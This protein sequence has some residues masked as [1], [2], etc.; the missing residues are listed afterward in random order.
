M[1]IYKKV[2]LDDHLVKV[3]SGKKRP[4]PTQENLNE[5]FNSM[6]GTQGAG[7]DLDLAS[8]EEKLREELTQPYIFRD[9][10]LNTAENI[11]IFG[12]FYHRIWQQLSLISLSV[13]I[14]H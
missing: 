11:L 8:P 4:A 14:Q 3:V 12:D 9:S 6:E 13:S 1:Q 10:S 7:E 2:L 5:S